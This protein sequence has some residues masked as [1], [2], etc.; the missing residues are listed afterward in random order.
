MAY[1]L[2]PYLPAVRRD[3]VL[4]LRSGKT[5]RQVALR[6]GVSPSAVS[7]W[8]RRMPEGSTE[9]IKTVSS[10][11][12]TH[13]KRLG[14]STIQ[15]IIDMRAKL[16]GRCAEVV[17]EQLQLEGTSVS[18]SSVKRTL[19]RNMLTKKRSPWKHVHEVLERPKA[20]FPGALVEVDT[21]HLV[22]DRKRI[23]I[24]TLLDVFTRH[25]YAWASR[26]INTRMSILFLKKA[27]TRLP[28]GFSMVQSDN[29]SEFSQHFTE[30]INTIHRHSRVR[31]PNDNAHLERFNRTIQDEF[32]RRMPM[33]VIK[34]NRMLPRY[35]SYY[36]NQRLHLGLKLKTP[37]QMLG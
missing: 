28:F 27:K 11:P 36:N 32:L 14:M 4:M 15:K 1:S 30:R 25:A 23:Y 34:I 9:D 18:L 3:A 12:H 17:H 26:R 35:L 33:D 10:R 5:V 24:Y 37:A 16:S 8:N 31:T 13:P 19:D 2:N 22:Y 20:L 7:K 29:G 6:Y 21:I